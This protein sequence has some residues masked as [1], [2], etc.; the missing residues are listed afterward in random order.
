MPILLEYLPPNRS[1]GA[2]RQLYAGEEY[3]R[4]DLTRPASDVES[5]LLGAAHRSAP[6]YYDERSQ[7]PLSPKQP[8][9][10]WAPSGRVPAKFLGYLP[11]NPNQPRQP[12]N[13]ANI[14]NSGAPAI[15]LR[16]Y[17]KG[18]YP[19]SQ[20]EVLLGSMAA[21]AVS[22]LPSYGYASRPPRGSGMHAVD[23]TDVGPRS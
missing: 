1:H 5:N 7:T 22:T 11:L 15:P 2:K 4:P 13:D 19:P 18:R 17:D 12:Q 9:S 16:S 20:D 14:F 21:L 23:T 8:M 3:C 10:R 6:S